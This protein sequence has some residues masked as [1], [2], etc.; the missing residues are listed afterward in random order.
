MIR[1]CKAPVPR[2]WG[3]SFR[4]FRVSYFGMIYILLFVFYNQNQYDAALC[5]KADG[6]GGGCLGPAL[7]AARSRTAAGCAPG[8]ERASLLG[9]LTKSRPVKFLPGGGEKGLYRTRACGV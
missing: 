2:K 7:S 6:S 4:I 9:E 3:G 1:P 8:G 5:A